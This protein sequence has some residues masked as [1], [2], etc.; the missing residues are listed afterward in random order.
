M[1]VP[2]LEFEARVFGVVDEDLCPD[3]TLTLA[4]FA[5]L[6][7]DDEAVALIE[8]DCGTILP[9]AG[10]GLMVGKAGEGKT[11]L[12]I[13]LL[14]HASI[15]ADFLGFRFPRPLRSLF[16]ENEGPQKAFRD[17]VESRL[18][19]WPTEVDGDGIVR[20]W[21][22]EERWGL[23]ALN[24]ESQREVLRHVVQTHRIDLVV[25]DSLTRFG[26]RGNGTP[27]ETRDFMAWL[28]DAGLGRDLSFLLLHHPRKEPAQ[29]DLDTIAGA[30][31]QH[32]DA[33][34]MLR[35]LGTNQSQLSYPKLRFARGQR[36]A[37]ILDF[38]P[39]SESF[40][41]VGD[42]VKAEGRDLLPL[43]REVLTDADWLAVSGLRELLKEK[44]GE[45]A[46]EKRIRET[47]HA[48]PDEFEWAM[49]KDIGKRAGTQYYRARIPHEGS[50]GSVGNVESLFDAEEENSIPT[51]P[52]PYKGGGAGGDGVDGRDEGE[53][54]PTPVGGNL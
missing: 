47:L 27:E 22:D 43:L 31:S 41:F 45:G 12:A 53:E 42:Q 33:I 17:K 39:E 35:K 40:T 13:D 8:G 48:Y 14:L 28:T 29:D 49:G 10:L 18:K 50:V 16:I 3:P 38:D 7:S 34:L 25:A 20:V 24:S 6:P 11:T 36:P 19:H 37:S 32:A 5:A 1:S 9:A 15:G 52:R 4:E 23:V 21:N 2:E 54:F 30:W 44:T 26:V 51:P 46:G